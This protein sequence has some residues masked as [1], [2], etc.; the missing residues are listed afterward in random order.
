LEQATPAH[1][2]ST[3]PPSLAPILSLAEHLRLGTFTVEQL[4]TGIVVGTPFHVPFRKAR[5]LWLPR[6]PT[7][8]GQER[9]VQ[10]GDRLV[11]TI[12]HAG[13]R[14]VEL[15]ALLAILWRQRSAYQYKEQP[16]ALVEIGIDELC[17]ETGFRS[18]AVLAALS[19]LEA[20]GIIGR[21]MG[22][23]RHLRSSYRVTDP[24][25]WTAER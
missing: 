7:K 22:G 24:A 12:L 2:E 11:L 5:P 18:S 21:E 14:H 17:A 3:S 20:R 23:G 8:T 25:K 13:L 4:D 9:F 15:A 16:Q 10:L 1:A 6:K 19:K